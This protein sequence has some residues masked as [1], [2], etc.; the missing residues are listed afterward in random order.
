VSLAEQ[1]VLLTGEAVP[2]AREEAER[3]L[4]LEEGA[5]PHAVLGAA[6]F[7]FD[8]DWPAARR[9]LER[10]VALE[11]HSPAALTTFARYLSAAG[12][13]ERAIA[14]V[15][16]AEA[17]DPSQHLVVHEAG[18]VYNRARRYDEA[19][20]KFLRAG[21]LDPQG[22][23]RVE[24]VK[25]NRFHVM[26]IHQQ[27][28]ALEAARRDAQEVMRLSS[29]P[30]RYIDQA[31]TMDPGRAVAVVLEKSL[32]IARGNAARDYVPPVRFAVLHAALGQDEEAL[33]WLLRAQDERSPSLVYAL[34]DPLF[35]RLRGD[36]R[37]QSLA[38]R[39]APP[40]TGLS[41][42]NPAT[43]AGPRLASLFHAPVH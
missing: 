3:A 8:W 4:A 29:V 16:R 34:A 36:A 39:V 26:L 17:I 40:V 14:L 2:R 42:E 33:A 9:E 6:S 18:W 28:G 32:E 5:G 24:W 30:Q 15:G 22:A 27:T 43:A 19:M 37:F 12:E 13:H 7:Y 11:P 1:G 41:A 38:A 20:R 10:A 21:T 25:W 31:G 23:N 35:D